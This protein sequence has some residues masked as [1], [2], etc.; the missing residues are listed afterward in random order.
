MITVLNKLYYLL[1]V[2]I[3]HITACTVL[4]TEVHITSA[5]YVPHERLELSRMDED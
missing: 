2:S 1:G 4:T 5:L 3:K